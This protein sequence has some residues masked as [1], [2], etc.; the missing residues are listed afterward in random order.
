MPRNEMSGQSRLDGDPLTFRKTLLRKPKP[1]AS[2]SSQ[3]MT[4]SWNLSSQTNLCYS[5]SRSYSRISILE[6]ALATDLKGRSDKE[7]GVG[8]HLLQKDARRHLRRKLSLFLEDICRCITFSPRG[9]FRI[10]AGILA[11]YPPVGSKLCLDRGFGSFPPYKHEGSEQ[12]H[13]ATFLAF[14]H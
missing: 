4:A 1:F 14:L 6:D 7:G 5:K 12:A 9:I 8:S 11:N 2:L 3:L 13:L 10:D